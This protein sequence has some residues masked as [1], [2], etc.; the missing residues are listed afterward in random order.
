[1]EYYQAFARRRS[2]GAAPQAEVKGRVDYIQAPAEQM[3][4]DDQSFDV[5][6]CV[7]LFHE[8]PKH[9][10]PQVAREIGRLLRPGGLLVITD[11]I[12]V[13]GQ[14]P[15][16]SVEVIEKEPV[17]LW[18]VHAHALQLGDRDSHNAG[19][20]NFSNLNEPYYL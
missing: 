19:L 16:V 20:G 3:P 1:M 12:Q 17:A 10:H 11:S 2:R 15:Y 9:V 7:Y 8:L 4:C 6:V 13:R 5:I 14:Q 18:C